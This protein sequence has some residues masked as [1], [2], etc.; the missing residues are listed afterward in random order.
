MRYWISLLYTVEISEV[1]SKAPCQLSKGFFFSSLVVTLLIIFLLTLAQSF[2][3]RETKS[4]KYIRGE[5]PLYSHQ[6]KS[7]SVTLC[8]VS[9][10]TCS[11]KQLLQHEKWVVSQILRCNNSFRGLCICHWYPFLLDIVSLLGLHFFLRLFVKRYPKL[12]NK[13]NPKRLS[14]LHHCRFLSK[15]VLP[16]CV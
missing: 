15:N 7:K 8:D 14:W 13:K 12:S 11:C 5:T 1:L 9:F 6:R 16:F 4:F 10:T 3:T 2:L